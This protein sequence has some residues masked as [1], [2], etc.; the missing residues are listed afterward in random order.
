MMPLMDGETAIRTLQQ[1]NPQV[2]VIAMS[3]LLSN[4]SLAEANGSI[5]QG[6]LAKPFSASELLDA[7]ARVKI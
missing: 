3:G 6:F 7:L 2:K 5:F 1:I 4:E